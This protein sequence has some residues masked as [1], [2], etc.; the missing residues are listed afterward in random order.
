MSLAYADSVNCVTFFEDL[1]LN[2]ENFNLTSTASLY[3]HLSIYIFV[4]CKK[5]KS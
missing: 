2:L 4:K 5:K 3:V 1:L